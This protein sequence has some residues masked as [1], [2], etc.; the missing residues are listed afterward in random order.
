MATKIQK[1]TRQLAY[2]AKT[3]ELSLTLANDRS[4]TTQEQA[5][6]LQAR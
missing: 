2:L 4:V 1:V 5:S 3:G 6:S